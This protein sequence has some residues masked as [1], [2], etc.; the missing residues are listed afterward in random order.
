MHRPASAT[1]KRDR[2]ATA[3]LTMVNV[4]VKSERIYKRS[5][6][7]NEWRLWKPDWGK[8]EPKESK[9]AAIVDEQRG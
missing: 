2:A 5:Y 4:M 1:E 9:R 8:G 3:A 7:T 6:A